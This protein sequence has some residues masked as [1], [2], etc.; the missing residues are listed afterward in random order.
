MACSSLGR[1]SMEVQAL[2]GKYRLDIDQLGS[3]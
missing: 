1:T 3:D 2:W